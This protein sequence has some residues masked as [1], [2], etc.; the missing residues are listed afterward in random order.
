MRADQKSLGR[1]SATADRS[2]ANV[3]ELDTA[4]KKRRSTTE[5]FF[6]T[7]AKALPGL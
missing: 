4:K 7:S 3:R 1:E 2:N 5:F 6:I